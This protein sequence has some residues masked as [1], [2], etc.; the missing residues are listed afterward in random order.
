MIADGTS[1]FLGQTVQ[2]RALGD[3]Y[4]GEVLRLDLQLVEDAMDRQLA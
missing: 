4:R 2:M 1:S 3:A